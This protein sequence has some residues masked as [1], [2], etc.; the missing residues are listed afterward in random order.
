MRSFFIVSMNILGAM[1]T[2]MVFIFMC[3]RAF[4][5]VPM[6]YNDAIALLAAIGMTWAVLSTVRYRND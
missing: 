2:L 4:G 3:I 6:Y 5:Q 1:S